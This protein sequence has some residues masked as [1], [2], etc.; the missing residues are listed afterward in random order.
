LRRL[1]AAMACLFAA[2][3]LT[4]SAGTLGVSSGTPSEASRWSADHLQHHGGVVGQALY[5]GLHRLVQDVGVGIVVVLLFIV[6]ASLLTG[7]SLGGLL[8]ALGRA[9]ARTASAAR[10]R[11][12]PRHDAAAWGA[13]ERPVPVRGAGAPLA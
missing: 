3:T 11:I 7:T 13:A 9:C 10:A 5:E 12:A 2:I 4:W 1:R 8:G 6:G